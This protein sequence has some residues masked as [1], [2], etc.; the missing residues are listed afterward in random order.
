MIGDWSLEFVLLYNRNVYGLTMIGHS[1]ELKENYCNEKLVLDSLQF[2]KY[3]W[4]ICVDLKIVNFLLGHQSGYTNS[5]ASS[6]IWIVE[7]TK[8]Q[9]RSFLT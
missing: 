6:G 3:N 5:L 9:L 1:V 4:K 7:K 2:E 8:A